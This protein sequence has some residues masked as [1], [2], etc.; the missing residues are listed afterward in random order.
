A[1]DAAAASTTGFCPGCGRTRHAGPWV[2]TARSPR[3]FRS[4][5]TMSRSTASPRRG[6]SLTGGEPSP[7]FGREAPGFSHGDERPLPNVSN[8]EFGM[9]NSELNAFTP[10]SEFGIPHSK[11][12][13]G[14]WDRN[15]HRLLRWLSGNTVEIGAS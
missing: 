2:S 5:R 9:G 7:I 14:V 10:H 8:A 12:S 1:W 4:S 3:S 15:S 13:I 11:Q 6:E